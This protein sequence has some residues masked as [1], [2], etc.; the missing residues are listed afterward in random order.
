MENPYAAHLAA[1]DEK[2]ARER[3]SEVRVTLKG[4]HLAALR[5]LLFP[6]MQYQKTANPEKYELLLEIDRIMHA[7]LQL[8]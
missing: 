2:M 4:K 1:A 5:S 7:G 6:E 8:V 3:E